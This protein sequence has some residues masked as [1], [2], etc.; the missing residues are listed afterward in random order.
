MDSPMGATPSA[1]ERL[2]E[3]GRRFPAF[4][5]GAQDFSGRA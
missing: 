2:F 1:Q 4:V 5:E 3:V